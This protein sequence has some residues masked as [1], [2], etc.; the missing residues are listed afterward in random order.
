M[1][2]TV[3]TTDL[4][5]ALTEWA[6][7]NGY[8]LVTD[9]AQSRVISVSAATDADIQSGIASITETIKNNAIQN[10]PMIF[11]QAAYLVRDTDSI[12]VAR[13]QG[14][15]S[16][17][18]MISYARGQM[19][20][21]DGITHQAADIYNDTP[22]TTKQWVL[23]ILQAMVDEDATL[24]DRAAAAT[25]ILDTEEANATLRGQLRGIRD[26]ARTALIAA[27]TPAQVRTACA[28]ARAS[29]IAAVITY[30]T[31]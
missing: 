9:D 14:E 4:F 25:R 5:P 2:V 3:S 26:V 22:A 7:D 24:A 30:N 15:N 8:Q 21:Y 12:E 31:P 19:V 27:T 28:T 23:D 13:S 16:V 6:V 18:A 11:T 29:L 17:L 1:A 20:V 10:Q